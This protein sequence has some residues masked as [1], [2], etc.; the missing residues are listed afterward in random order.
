MLKELC[1][2]LCCNFVPNLHNLGAHLR[3][4]ITASNATTMPDMNTL[5]FRTWQLLCICA[6]AVYIIIQLLFFTLHAYLQDSF[7][8]EEDFSPWVADVRVVIISCFVVVV[9]IVFGRA[10]ISSSFSEKNSEIRGNLAITAAVCIT[11]GCSTAMTHFWNW[12]GVCKDAF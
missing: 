7:C 3:S 2:F 6:T 12:G 1:V 9:P 5:L 10:F 11:A 8:G 4:K